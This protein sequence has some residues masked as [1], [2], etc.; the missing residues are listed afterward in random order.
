MVSG[1]ARKEEAPVAAKPIPVILDTDIG[2]DIDDT[3]ALA[4]LLRCPELDL[5]LVT[6]STGDVAYRARLTAK[7]LR[8]FGRPDVPVGIGLPTDMKPGHRTQLPCAEGFDLAAHPGG[9]RQDGAEALV[10]AI[11][12]SPEPVTVL[13]IGPLT[14][15]AAA[16]ER[17]PGIAGRARFV[18]M[19][20]SIAWSHHEG[21]RPI[22]EY[23]VVHDAPAARRVFSASWPKVVTPLDTCGRVRLMGDKYRAVAGSP[24]PFARTVIANY[25][26]WKRSGGWVKDAAA[27]SILFD[28]VAVYLAFA[29]GLLEM[30]EMPLA[31][32]EDGFTRQD[33]AGS[34][35]RVATA[36]R[37]LPAFEDLIVDRLTSGPR[38]SAG[39]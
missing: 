19:H 27:S 3:W 2:T 14:T 22:A 12:E 28:C 29:E 10:R 32:S 33:P 1:G 38:G 34:A 37:D 8:D 23:N 11:M 30:R 4:M 7:L 5:R 15:V 20:G 6:A 26:V 36:W 17:E 21:H 31:V 25:E 35:C 16:L 9:V 39:A 24:D 13:A 18:G